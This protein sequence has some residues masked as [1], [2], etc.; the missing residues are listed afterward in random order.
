[1]CGIAG[2]LAF[3]GGGFAVDGEFVTRMR[4]AMPHR[5]PDGA[6]TWVADD[7]RVG[8]GFRRLAIIDLSPAAMQ[9]MPNEDGTIRLVFNGEIYNH[10]EIRAE[11]EA[12]GGHRWRTDHA[13]GEVIVHAFEEWGIECLRRFRGMFAFALWDGRSGELWL[14][15]DRIGIKPL[16]WAVHHGRLVF[17]SEIKALLTDPQ[18][19]RAVD[20]ESLY[21]YLSFLTAPAPGTLFRGI[22]K[23]PGGT[24]LRAGLD[25]DVRVERWW[26]AWDEV[27]PLEGRTDAELAALL[28]DELRTSV[29]YRKVSDVPVGVFLSGGIDSSTNAMLFSEG[30]ERPVQTFSIGYDADYASYP[31]ELEWAKLAADAAGAAYHERILSLD[32]ALAFLPEMVRLQDEPIADPVCVPLY[33]VSE[34]ARAQGVVVAHAGEGADEL[35]HGYPRWKAML[36]LERANALP[37]PRLAKRLGLAALGAAHAGESWH[38]EYLRRGTEGL[39][40]FWGGAEA[41]TEA[42]KAKL[43]SPRLR[44]DLGGLSSWDTLRP[45]R[46]RFDAGAWEPSALNWMT[47]LDLN[48]RLPELLLMRVDK[49]SM[50]VGLE[51]RVPFLDHRVVGLALSMPT[52]A[53][54]RGGELK[55]LLKLAVRGLLPDVLVDRPKQGFRMPVD[56][57]FDER[58]GEHTR[59]ELDAF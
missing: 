18:L 45:I 13:D 17:A 56:E 8:L 4:E 6:E 20:E 30:E 25:G 34:L 39:P 19:E 11:L 24:W 26:D 55:H 3:A 22:S 57:W 50:G 28:L 1:M 2:A 49:M 43:L 32:D 47:Y 54:T 41:F 35:F 27:E 42:S 33:Y 23:L 59:R 15:R 9:P 37:V 16:Y 46:A 53:K 31:N 40:V 29:R 12:L 21:H 7:A 48:L 5:G 10:A 14:V 36:G 51:A 52:A 58:L 38:A 44:A